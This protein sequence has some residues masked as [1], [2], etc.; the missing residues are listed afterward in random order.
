MIIITTPITLLLLIII[1][2]IIINVVLGTPHKG[3]KKICFKKSVLF[4]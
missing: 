4:Y 1:I 3:E 2:I